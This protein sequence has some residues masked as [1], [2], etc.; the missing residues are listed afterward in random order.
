MIRPVYLV[1]DDEAKRWSHNTS[2]DMGIYSSKAQE[3]FSRDDLDMAYEEGHQDGV[4]DR[5]EGWKV[6]ATTHQLVEQLI[7]H[8]G[9]PYKENQQ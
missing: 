5:I 7:E 1:W 2:R 3:F 6:G 8:D 9:M 4:V